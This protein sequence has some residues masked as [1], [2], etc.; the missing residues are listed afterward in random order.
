MIDIIKLNDSNKIWF[1]SDI[2][3]YHKNIT[4]GESTWENK[5]INCRRF[6]TV[7]LMTNHILSQINKYVKEDDI[8]IDLGDWSFGGIENIWNV[9]KQ[10]NVKSIYHALGNHDSHIQKNYI[11]PNVY[12]AE[13]YS[14]KL[15]DGKGIYLSDSEYPDYVEARTL[16]TEVRNYY[17]FLIGDTLLCSMHYPIEEWNDRGNKK[18]KNSYMI[19]GHSHGACPFKKGRLD[20]GIDNAYRIFGE[21]KPF[22]Y[23]EIIQIIKSQ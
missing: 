17:E 7:E 11:L 10:L 18:I 9:R 16:F 19:H 5:E 3:G 4:Y 15:L 6:D 1:T 21:Y 22:S 23:N 20:V 14:S 2:H 13:P 12:R 8:L